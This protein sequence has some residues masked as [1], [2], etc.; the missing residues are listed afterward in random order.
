MRI[1]T[2]GWP[3]DIQQQSHRIVTL[4]L[5]VQVN[6][7]VG[8]ASVLKSQPLRDA[9]LLNVDNFEDGC[10]FNDGNAEDC[11]FNDGQ[12]ANERPDAFKV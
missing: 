10:Y 7:C 5:A 12:G 9:K 1:S 4:R 6:G 3:A 8:E 2:S 11:Y